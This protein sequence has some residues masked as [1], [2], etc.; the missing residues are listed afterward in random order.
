MVDT[1]IYNFPSRSK[2]RKD[3]INEY[4]KTYNSFTYEDLV[5]FLKYCIKGEKQDAVKRELIDMTGKLIPSNKVNDIMG[6][7]TVEVYQNQL[8]FDELKTY[9]NLNIEKVLEDVEQYI[10]AQIEGREITGVGEKI[11]RL[12]SS[13]SEED[14]KKNAEKILQ[15]MIQECC[16][17]D[18]DNTV[19]VFSV[20]KFLERC[21]VED[22]ETKEELIGSVLLSS[23]EMAEKGVKFLLV[24]KIPHAIMREQI[25]D[26]HWETK[27]LPKENITI[28]IEKELFL[29]VRYTDT[30]KYVFEI[31]ERTK[32][33]YLRADDGVKT[34]ED[35][36]P[37]N[38]I[39]I[40][41]ISDLWEEFDV[42]T[43]QSRYVFKNIRY[44]VGN[45]GIK[46]SSY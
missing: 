37:P 30:H 18:G 1:S 20:Q 29:T 25:G 10:L 16:I 40:F 23:Y 2:S 9:R 17:K 24:E 31:E 22:E 34:G 43:E 36:S 19:C 28:A 7:L 14:M 38:E 4:L 44:Y 12:Y 32:K 45:K 33:T 6:F 13:S 27:Y 46:S 8:R 15:E 26:T 35:K 3:I 21:G 39:R 11:A 5:A 42:F 41:E